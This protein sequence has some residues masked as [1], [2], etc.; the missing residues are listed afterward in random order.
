MNIKNA[1]EKARKAH[2]TAIEQLY[3][4]TCTV[5]EYK[6]VK[7]IMEIAEMVAGE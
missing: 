3:E 7:A 4:D 2:R 6:P 5:Y 1:I